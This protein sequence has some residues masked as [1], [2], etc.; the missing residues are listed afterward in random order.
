[1][2]SGPFLRTNKGSFG[3]GQTVLVCIPTPE[4]HLKSL[5]LSIEYRLNRPLL[6]SLF[7]YSPLN[8]YFSIPNPPAMLQKSLFTLFILGSLCIL[9]S[10]EGRKNDPNVSSDLNRPANRTKTDSSAHKPFIPAHIDSLD[11]PSILLKK[12]PLWVDYCKSKDR[13]FDIHT[14]KQIPSTGYAAEIEKPDST[15]IDPD[16]YTYFYI[17]SP[18]SR[19]MLDIYSYRHILNKDAKGTM[20]IGGGDPESTIEILDTKRHLWQ[21]ILMLG[22]QEKFDD[23]CWVSNSIFLIAG[24]TQSSDTLW[25][26]CFFLYDIEQQRSVFGTWPEHTSCSNKDYLENWKG[27]NWK[28]KWE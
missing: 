6:N 1:M 24:S 9:S 4:K 7:S 20:H 14:F 2:Q 17:P 8:P 13:I 15:K 18:D 25:Q 5:F 22:S 28:V 16:Q 11:V 23:A 21:R 27:K 19:I 26:P 3:L 10:C 12:L